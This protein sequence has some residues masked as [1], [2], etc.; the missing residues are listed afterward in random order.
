MTECVK[1]LK[2]G[3]KAAGVTTTKRVI[4][5]RRAFKVRNGDG[6]HTGRV[7]Y[8]LT[9]VASTWFE[10]TQ[11][12]VEI[13]KSWFDSVDDGRGSFRSYWSDVR[14]NFWGWIETGG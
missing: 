3:L 13:L 8:E 5:L 12:Q 4:P 9:G 14:Q 2:A 10:G 7:G 11:E 1:R 6:E